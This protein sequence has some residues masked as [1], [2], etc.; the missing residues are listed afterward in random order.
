MILDYTENRTATVR[1]LSAGVWKAEAAVVDTL[2][3][4]RISLEIRLPELAISEASLEVHR[5]SLPFPDVSGKLERLTGVRVGPGMTKIVNGL[6]GGEGGSDTVA[7]LIFE[8]MEALILAYTAR[9]FKTRGFKDVM[10]GPPVEEG[11]VQ[12]N[13]WIIGPK[14]VVE[15]ARENPRLANSCIA[16]L[17]DSK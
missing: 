6:V 3:H 14:G 1:E 16:F 2:I 4:V 8:A 11:K 9:E 13:P 12:R 10:P 5:S 7:N 15:M 17:E